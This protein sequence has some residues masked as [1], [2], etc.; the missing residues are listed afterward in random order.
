M[1]DSVLVAQ[2][3]FQHM[4]L[5]GGSA[6]EAW[7]EDPSAP[8][9]QKLTKD[10]V[11]VWRLQVGVSTYRGKGDM[12]YVSVAAKENPLD[13][14]GIGTVVDFDGLTMGVSKTKSGHSIWWTADEVH[15]AAAVGSGRPHLAATTG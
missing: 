8:K 15:A 3:Q 2:E 13:A 6:R 1:I 9:E 11:P 14:L 7:N 4:V 10:G 5:M 12:L